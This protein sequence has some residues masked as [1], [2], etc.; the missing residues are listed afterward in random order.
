[1]KSDETIDEIKKIIEEDLPN[2]DNIDGDLGR[3]ELT[4]S[5]LQSSFTGVI[6]NLVKTFPNDMELGSRVREFVQK[7]DKGETVVDKNKKINSYFTAD[8]KE[9]EKSSVE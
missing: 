2:K 1:M 5:G 3:T 6:R 7:V 8:I 9:N 4:I